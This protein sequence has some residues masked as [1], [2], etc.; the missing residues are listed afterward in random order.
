MAGWEDR[1]YPML[2][3]DY[4]PTQP[5]APTA[6]ECDALGMNLG[7]SRGAVLAQWN[8]GRS[9]VLGQKN[10]ASEQLRDYLRRRGWL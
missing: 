7:R 1:D 8:D 5:I 6:G 3:R 4:L 10:A 9:V 2:F